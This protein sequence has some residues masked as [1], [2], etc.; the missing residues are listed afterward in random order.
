VKNPTEVPRRMGELRSPPRHG[1]RWGLSALALLAAILFGAILAVAGGILYQQ[2]FGS[3]PGEPSVVSAPVIK[4]SGS[5]AI[6]PAEIYRADAPGVVL[7]ES[8]VSEAAVGPFGPQKQRGTA[9]GSGFMIDGQG[10]ILTNYHVV[11]GATKTTVTLKDG[12]SY[13]ASIVGSDPSTDVALLRI[14]AP[15]SELK[16][17]PL[18]D[19]S[20]LA[21]GQPVVAIGNPLGYSGTET[22]GIVSALHRDIQAPNGFDIPGAIQTDTPMTNGSSGGPLIDSSGRVVGIDAQV[23]ADQNGTSQADGIG[24][25][26]PINTAKDVVQQLAQNG[27]VVHPYLGISGFGITSEMANLFPTDRG[28]AVAKV[29]HGSPAQKAGIKGGDQVQDVGGTRIITGGD[30]IVAIDGKPVTDM[31]QLQTMIS[32]DRVGQQVSVKILRGSQTMTVQV[33][34]GNRPQNLQG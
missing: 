16:P 8:R 32:N 13:D 19:S 22:Q 10:S 2:R 14:N 33:T 3:S 18:G 17:L 28:V 30:V 26:V 34:L 4:N 20:R 29:A 31:T 12:R 24:F 11:A 7:I 6:N 5:A 15:S 23:A 27:K 9:E 25:A 21:V 1:R